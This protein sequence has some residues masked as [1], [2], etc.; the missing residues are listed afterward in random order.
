VRAVGPLRPSGIAIR[1]AF[2][3]LV[4]AILGL[5]VAFGLALGER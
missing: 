4:L 1:I 2:M 3:L 5:L